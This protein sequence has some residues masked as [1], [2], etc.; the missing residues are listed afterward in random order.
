MNQTTTP[1]NA[2]NHGETGTGSGLT[3]PLS[4]TRSPISRSFLVSWVVLSFLFL[5]TPL[6]PSMRQAF[7]SFFFSILMHNHHHAR[8]GG[9]DIVLFGE[10]LL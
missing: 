2:F 5:S 1:R 8:Q 6:H 9:G 10:L 7:F 4:S 3:F